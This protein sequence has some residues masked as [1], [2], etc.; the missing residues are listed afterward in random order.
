MNID[1]FVA[2]LDGVRPSKEG[3]MALCPAHGDKNPSLSVNVGDGGRI[4]LY[5]HARCSFESIVAALGLEAS[6]L[7]PDEHWATKKCGSPVDVAYP[8]VDE[9]R[10]LLYEVVRRP[11][12]QFRQRRPDGHGG[13]NWGLGDVRRVLYRLPSVVEAVSAGRQVFIVEG[14][15]DADSGAA[16][17]LVT[18]CNPMGAGNW[19]DE[20][21]E[22]FRGYNG[23][24]VIIADKDPDRDERGNVHR[25]GQSHAGQVA[26]SLAAVGVRVGVL[27]LPDRGGLRIKDLSDWINGGGTREE[28]EELIASRMANG[29]QYTH[30]FEAWVQAQDPPPTPNRPASALTIIS[31]ADLARK[32]IP[33]PRWA[34]PGL[35]PEGLVILAGRPKV[36]K[37]WL[38][39][40]VALAV[41]SGEAALRGVACEPGDVLYFALED[42]LR[43]LQERIKQ[44][45]V[46]PSPR[47]DLATEAPTVGAG[48]LEAVGEWLDRHPT[49]R[50]VVVDTLARIRP[51]RK[52]GGDVYGEDTAAL[53]GIQR[54]ALERGVCV[55]LLHHLRKGTTTDPVDSVSGTAAIAGVPDAVLVLQKTKRQ[56]EATLHL[57]GR[58]VEESDLLLSWNA[59]TA[60][61]ILVDHC[62]DAGAV[63]ALTEERRRIL[64]VLKGRDA[65][66]SPSEIAAAL[67]HPEK[68]EST[69]HL[70]R[71]LAAEGLIE[72]AGYGHYKACSLTPVTD[73]GVHSD[74]AVHDD[75]AATVEETEPQS[76]S[77]EAVAAAY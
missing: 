46:T 65:A 55:L 62:A 68:A 21:S 66:L 3:Y 57:T 8:Y 45:G 13:W 37:S 32:S 14:E 4:L 18:T 75:P 31:A 60:G 39:L 16:L 61:W 47:L 24:V 7:G 44:L 34:V 67:G 58:D 5:C 2:R 77:R 19:R 10:A 76:T 64:D 63:V 43:R 36:G 11:G 25:K 73:H 27:E 1:D 50:L 28:L 70:V 20:Y 6:D 29:V 23:L 74:P 72:S 41:A 17:G 71:K 38:A 15:K 51:P 12:K 59:R 48:F 30:A 35:L 49:S 69:R 40:D 42:N 22:T 26:R 33:D 52:R 56:G 9:S 53:A 54:M